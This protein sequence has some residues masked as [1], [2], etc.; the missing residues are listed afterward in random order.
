[1]RALAEQ[2]LRD[3]PLYQATQAV[4]SC[5]LGRDGEL[6]CLRE[7]LGRHNALDKVIGCALLQGLDLSACM[8]FT[9]GRLPTDMLRKVIR[10]GIPLL[11]SKTYPTELSVSLAKD[12]GLTLVTLRKDGAIFSWT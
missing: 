4:H 10:A 7:D 1:M 5:A 3:A 2:A 12:T 9:T 8:L 6:L 11:I